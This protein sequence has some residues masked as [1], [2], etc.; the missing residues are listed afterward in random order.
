MGHVVLASR[1][2]EQLDEI[3][4]RIKD[5]GGSRSVVGTD[6]SSP[7]SI[8]NL[9]STVEKLGSVTVVVN[10]SGAGQFG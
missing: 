4:K 7:E 6:V 1:S 5:E 3:A 2:L 8:K 10:N 9:K